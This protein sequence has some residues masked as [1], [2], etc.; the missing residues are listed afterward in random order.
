MALSILPTIVAAQINQPE[1]RYRWDDTRASEDF[2][3]PAPMELLKGLEP[4]TLRAKIAVA[5]GMYEWIVFRFQG[6]LADPLPLDLAEGAWCANIDRTYMEYVELDR[7]DWLGPIRGPIWCAATWLLPAI[8]FSDDQPEEWES[9]AIYLSR[10]A[11]HVLPD[12]S[13][14]ERWLGATVERL[15]SLYSLPPPDRFDDLFGEHEEDRRGPLI[16]REAIEPAFPYQPEGARRLI[17]TFLRSVDYR[18]NKLLRSPTEM[19]ENGFTGTPYNVE[20]G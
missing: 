7:Q 3:R 20:P 18:T 1:L 13:V 11:Q 8:Y 4:V 10:L 2:L 15:A 12:P 16:A 19:L 9:G 17:D 6:L 14:F 5:I